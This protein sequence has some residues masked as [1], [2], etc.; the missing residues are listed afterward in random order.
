[1]SAEPFD[2]PPESP[3]DELSAAVE[4]ARE[5]LQNP[6][7]LSDRIAMGRALWR[8]L[9]VGFAAQLGE[10][11]LGLSQLAAL[12][13][14]DG[15]A[16]LTVGDLAEHLGRSPSATSRIVSSLVER[17]LL[18][19]SEEEADRR[20]RTLAIT[21]AGTQLLAQVDRARADQFLAVVR[22]LPAPERA[23]VAMGVAALSEHAITR[24]GR[25]LKAPPGS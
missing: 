18:G 19:R 11:R 21:E 3:G 17:G 12:Y 10:L 23:L 4:S 25:L 13:A 9:V 6:R 24:R 20:Q 15:G 1:M 16:T 2:H 5:H 22:R 14:V 7:Q 8:D